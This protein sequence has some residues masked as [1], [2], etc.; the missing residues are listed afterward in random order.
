MGKRRRSFRPSLDRLDERRLL[1]GLSAAQ[2]SNTYGIDA[3]TFRS[4]SGAIVPGNG[5]GETIAL[6][7]AYHNPVLATDLHVFDQANNLPDPHL[8]V[9]DQ[10]GSRTNATWASEETL[11]VE[12]AHAMAPGANIV[13]VEARSQTLRSLMAP[14]IPRGRR[15]A[16][17]WSR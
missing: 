9:I 17:W 1:S 11:D 4:A 5:A 7:E 12:A 15:R 6:V 13:V 14:W 10:A 8:S 16:S 3:I 2:L